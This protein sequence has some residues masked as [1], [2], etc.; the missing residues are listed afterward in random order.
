MRLIQLF[1]SGAIILLIAS[2]VSTG[3][4]Q[5]K[6]E[7]ADR[8]QAEVAQLIK[9]VAALT[10]ERDSLLAEVGRL[11]GENA[12][13]ASRVPSLEEANASLQAAM[14]ASKSE[15][16]QLILQLTNDKQALESELAS[17][18][19]EHQVLCDRIAK[20]QQ[21]QAMKMAELQ[22]TYGRL[23]EGLTEQIELGQIRIDSLLGRLNVHIFDQVLFLS[24]EAVVRTSGK[25][26]LEAVA[27]AFETAV[28]QRIVIEG[29]TDNVPIG[30]KLRDRYATNWELST[31]R[32]TNV[33]RYL[34]E[35]GGVN[36]GKISVAAYGEYKPIATNTTKE[37]RSQNRRIE[38]HFI[39]ED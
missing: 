16:D 2:C 6:V 37:G 26:V 4:F 7:E 19:V 35:Q 17:L 30:E 25:K 9:E 8:F 36:P 39:P 32:A 21:E 15:K 29:H 18:Q 14:E 28:G 24:G 20:E 33:T 38:I 5:A 11:Q 13:L 34:I 31:T 10:A 27:K 1:I 22:S 3:K 23:V 12:E